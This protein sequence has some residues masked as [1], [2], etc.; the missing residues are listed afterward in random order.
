MKTVVIAI[1]LTLLSVGVQAAPAKRVCKALKI[2][3]CKKRVDCGWV[4]KHVRK[5]GTIVA[6]HCRKKPS[7]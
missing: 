6:G 7:N 5:N 3:Q 2:T 4:K 1:A